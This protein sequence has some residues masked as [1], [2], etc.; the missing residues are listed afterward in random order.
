MENSR[1]HVWCCTPAVPVVR[2]GSP[3]LPSGLGGCP[4]CLAPGLVHGSALGAHM[5]FEN[6]LSFSVFN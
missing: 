4:T 1:G 5:P 3:L 6:A 2:D